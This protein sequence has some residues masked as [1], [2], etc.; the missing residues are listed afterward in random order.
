[1]D[2]FGARAFAA[3]TLTA[4]LAAALGEGFV[5]VTAGFTVL[6]VAMSFYKREAIQTL[7]PNTPS[8]FN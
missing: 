2:A 5:A 1:M 4:G 8:A 6:E 3:V 7:N